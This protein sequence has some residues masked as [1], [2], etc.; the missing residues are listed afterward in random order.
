MCLLTRSEFS[1]LLTWGVDNLRGAF[2]ETT[3]VH[4]YA[5]SKREE[6]T[7]VAGQVGSGSAKMEDG[8]LRKVKLIP[9]RTKTRP[10]LNF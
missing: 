7:V 2:T 9:T 5:P 8:A 10:I 4:P 3:P 6:K 1:S